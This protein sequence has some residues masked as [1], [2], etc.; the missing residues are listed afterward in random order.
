[1]SDIPFEAVF[2]QTHEISSYRYCVSSVFPHKSASL[3]IILLDKAKLEVHRIYKDLVKE[4]YDNWGADDKYLDDIVEAE[5]KKVVV[6]QLEVV[7]EK[8]EVVVA[9]EAV[10]EEV[11]AEE[12]KL[13]EVAV[14]EKA[15]EA[16]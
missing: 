6:P 16:E 11:V 15:E 13:E 7:W 5:V 12:E 2:V 4:E 10:A 14:E 1:M 3:V 9:E 8:E